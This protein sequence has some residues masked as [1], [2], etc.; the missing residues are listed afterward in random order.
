MAERDQ[1]PSPGWIQ[2]LLARHE[3]SLI[4]YA[5]RITHNAEQARDVVQETFL[6][7]CREF[8]AEINGHATAWLYT[9]CRHRAIDMRRKEQRMSPTLDVLQ[10]TSNAGEHDPHDAAVMQDEFRQ[11]YD[12][13]K[14]LPDNQQEVIRLKFQSGLSYKEISEVTGTSVTQ[15]G[16][17]IH[18]GIKML[19]Q[20]CGVRTAKSDAES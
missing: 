16:V 3:A 2:Q 7:L 4:R 9:V 14:H 10:L 11:I 20:Q 1:R 12:R 19:R 8:P 6:K 15:V 13:F 5:Y 18:C 17:L